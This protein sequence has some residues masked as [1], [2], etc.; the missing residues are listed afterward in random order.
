M[1]W[2][3]SRSQLLASRCLAL[4]PLRRSCLKSPPSTTLLSGSGLST[5]RWSSHATWVVPHP[6]FVTL[7]TFPKTSGTTSSPQQSFEGRTRASLSQGG[8]GSLLLPPGTILSPR[9]WTPPCPDS[10]LEDYRRSKSATC[11]W[12]A[13]LPAF[14]LDSPHVR[15]SKLPSPRRLLPAPL[16][17]RSPR[18]PA[19]TREWP[20]PPCAYRPWWTRHWTRYWSGCRGIKSAPS[21]QGTRRCV[22]LNPPTTSSR[23]RS[24]SVHCTRYSRPTCRRTLTSGYSGRTGAGCSANSRTWSTRICRTGRGSGIPPGPSTF[25]LWWA[26]YR[27]L[28]CALL[29]LDAVPPEVLDAYG[30]FIREQNQAYGRDAWFLV[31]QADVRM[32]SEQFDRL[33]R[34][35]ERQ[36]QLE[37]AASMQSHFDPAR[38]WSTV[39]HL[40]LADKMWWDEHLHRPVV[41]FLAKI[42]SRAQ[43]CDDGTT[44]PALAALDGPPGRSG[45]RTNNNNTRRNNRSRTPRRQQQ[46]GGGS[47]TITTN[48]GT[49]FCTAYNSPAGCSQSQQSCQ[50]F[51]GCTTCRKTGHAAHQCDPNRNS[52]G[53]K[54]GSRKQTR[55]AEARA[56]IE[57]CSIRL[58]PNPDHLDAFPR[59]RLR[60]PPRRRCPTAACLLS[61]PWIRP[62][63]CRRRPT[64]VRLPSGPWNRPR[65]RRRGP[66]R[67]RPPPGRRCHPHIMHQARMFCICSVVHSTG[68]TDYRKCCARQV[69]K[70][71]AGTWPT[72]ASRTRTWPMT[73]FGNGYHSG[74]GTDTTISSWHPRLA[75]HFRNHVGSSQDR[76]CCGAGNIVTDFPSPE[77]LSC[78]SSRITL[79]GFEWTICW[80][81]EQPRRA[82]QWMH[83]AGVG[84]WSSP[85]RGRTLCRCSIS[86]HS[87]HCERLVRSTS[88]ST[89]ANTAPSQ[90][91]RLDCCTTEWSATPSHRTCNHKPRTIQL[92]NGRT[93]FKRHPP[94]VGKRDRDGSYA[95]AAQAAYPTDLNAA[96][97]RCITDTIRSPPTHP[98]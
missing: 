43:V 37:Q 9:R 54:P 46:P 17:R 77:P 44:Q 24:R 68:P 45:G 63:L 69:A 76:L 33:R 97:A 28:R 79:S 48:R 22:E 64:A 11:T 67:F 1:Q 49:P 29:L 52:G 98:P 58:N 8:C 19:P 83:Y 51:H 61:K 3:P 85:S 65:L 60:P 10:Y 2:L 5:S 88:L 36:H 66:N 56:R 21:S 42:R 14:D 92:G 41:L 31:Y 80:L 35:A 7:S 34:R 81:K 32:R 84:L 27:V 38:P 4:T 13:G 40:A 6:A 25:D 82:P 57:R 72:R 70:W 16:P 87:R 62:L 93:C 15:R 75:A 30:E 91:S 78:D 74:S 94:T 95:T 23:R 73:Q 90:R 47:A 39:F 18:Q 20:S 71:T 12:C 96:L 26:S 50:Y 59:P 86:S 55:R 53:G 89:N